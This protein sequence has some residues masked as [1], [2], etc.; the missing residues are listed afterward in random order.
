MYLG[1]LFIKAVLRRGRIRT[2][3][4]PEMPRKVEAL[5]EAMACHQDCLRKEARELL[6]F[7]KGNI[8]TPGGTW[9]LAESVLLLGASGFVQ[10]GLHRLSLDSRGRNLKRRG[11]YVF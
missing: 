8:W 4:N 9:R 3:D 2:Q 6:V 10:T 11:W 1:S 5:L 7:G